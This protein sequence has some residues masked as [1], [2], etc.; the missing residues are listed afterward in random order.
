VTIKRNLSQSRTLENEVLKKIDFLLNDMVHGNSSQVK[1]KFFHLLRDFLKEFFN[2]NYEFTTKELEKDLKEINF[3]T[4]DQKKEL[5]ELSDK[6]DENQYSPEGFT[7]KELEEMIR[8]LRTIIVSLMEGEMSV[9]TKVQNPVDNM[10]ISAFK[11]YTKA[12]IRT[13]DKEL[14]DA[15]S[16]LY[17]GYES[18][19][20]GEF[21]LAHEESKRLLSMY[22]G[23]KPPLNKKIYPKII[24]LNKR[25]SES[26]SFERIKLIENRFDKTY[27]VLK[28][29]K[30]KDA[31]EHYLS[32]QRLYSTLNEKDKLLVY[33]EM[34]KM[35]EILK[36]HEIEE[37]KE[38]LKKKIID[39][40]NILK[41]GQVESAR[42]HY[43]ELDELFNKIPESYQKQFK[44]KI[45]GLYFQ[46]YSDI[47]S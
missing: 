10:I 45:D 34:N 18:L 31:K 44:K 35:F 30:T 41:E 47:R 46:L 15:Y 20:H 26:E 43:D 23:L 38:Q 40:H 2:L 3:I 7:D 29:G 42:S 39:I 8:R 6:L 17:K 32:A 16:I 1:G 12:I 27:L 22:A 28:A 14:R 5:V 25:I 36:K 37:R 13:K 11:I 21:G 33:H 19:L 9:G 4:E 24:E